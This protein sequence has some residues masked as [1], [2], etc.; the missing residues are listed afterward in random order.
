M[1]KGMIMIFWRIVAFIKNIL[2][3]YEILRFSFSNQAKYY[4]II[5]TTSVFSALNVLYS[6]VDLP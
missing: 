5:L 4:I 1:L 3:L 6:K 2:E